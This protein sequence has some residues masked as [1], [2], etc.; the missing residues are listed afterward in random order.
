MLSGIF[1]DLLPTLRFPSFFFF[2]G[3]GS[4]SEDICFF[5]GFCCIDARLLVLGSF[6]CFRFLVSLNFC[7]CKSRTLVSAAPFTIFDA[8]LLAFE[9]FARF[10]FPVSLILCSIE[11]SLLVSAAHCTSLEPDCSTDLLGTCFLI[12]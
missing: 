2:D 3:A 12:F 11:R 9:T 1:A 4:L 5:D 6:A 8:T 10:C 7:S